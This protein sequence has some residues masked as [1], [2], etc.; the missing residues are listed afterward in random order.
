MSLTLFAEP[1]LLRALRLLLPAAQADVG[2][3]A[4]V[5]QH[6]DMVAS[7]TACA[8][9][10]ASH[11]AAFQ[12]LSPAL[13]QAAARLVRAWH[14][15][16]PASVPMGELEI[17]AR[18]CP[19]FVSPAEREGLEDWL[20][21]TARTASEGGGGVHLRD[22]LLRR[23]ARLAPDAKAECFEAAALCALA[24]KKRK[25]AGLPAS[26]P[27]EL[28]RY[29]LGYFLGAGL[30]DKTPCR[31]RQR[32]N[33]IWLE[34]VSLTAWATSDLPGVTFAEVELVS[35]QVW[36]SHMEE[37]Q[38]SPA[39]V[40]VIGSTWLPVR[41]A[42]VGRRTEYVSVE[43]PGS[44]RFE[45][46]GLQKPAWAVSMRRD[47]EGLAALLAD[48]TQARWLPPSDG[49]EGGWDIGGWRSPG[50]IGRDRFGLVAEFN[51][52]GVVQRCRWIPAGRFLMGSPENEEGRWVD[53]GPQ[54][55]VTLSGY[56][57]A[58]TACTQALWRAVMGDNP[59][60]FQDDEHNPVDSVSWDD[61]RK[62]FGKLAALVPGLAA[63][64]PSEAHWE[65]ACRAGTVTPFSFGENITP[66]QVNYDGNNPYADGK[67]GVYRRK[68]VPAAS[69]PP[70]PWGL[71]EMHGN[72]WEWCAD[73]FGS[74]AAEPHPDPE[75][76]PQGSGR[77]LRGGFWIGDT[78][79]VRSAYRLVDVPGYRSHLFGLRVAPGRAGVGRN[80]FRQE[81]AE[82][83]V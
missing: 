37:G 19:E 6:P 32:G 26:L 46:N 72:V 29:D 18:L 44:E 52:A 33:E 25:E 70:N 2:L 11:E 8:F 42:T 17:F 28:S 7:A 10:S 50:N 62:F 59:S 20:R 61:C 53:E 69:L 58:D 16:R 3:E 79:S 1:P 15:G 38:V 39:S 56:W 65:Y 68:T 4:E 12:R 64:F 78:H 67:K 23:D 13:K 66:E 30:R 51:V 45:F 9:A 31:V 5:W 47:A 82:P 35:N 43:I 81:L 63:G 57:L 71:F 77:V 41:L 36:V 40:E 75:V 60:D 27:A 14:I 24:A 73:W 21:A 34:G 76:P 74:Y 55:E 48:G 54:H 49:L 80:L 22:W 83:A